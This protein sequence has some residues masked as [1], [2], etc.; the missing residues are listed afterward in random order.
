MTATTVYREIAAAG[1]LIASY[2]LDLVAR[3]GQQLLP[4]LDLLDGHL[5]SEPVILAHGFGGSRANFLAFAAYMRLAGFGKIAYFE[6]PRWQS[7]TDS[8]AQLRLMAQR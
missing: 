3:R 5:E 2:P 1:L 7:I 4:H 8:A 6:Y